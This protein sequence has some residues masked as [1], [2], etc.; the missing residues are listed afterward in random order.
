MKITLETDQHNK[1]VAALK[2]AGA[3]E[4]G[5]QLYGEQLAPSDFL[6]TDVTIQRR[7]GSVTQ[8]LVDLVQAARDA[9]RFFDR[10]R[11]R[12]SRFNYI[13]E[14]H[15]HPRFAVRPSGTDIETMRALV[16][17]P[18]FQ[19]SFAVLMIPDTPSGHF[20]E[21]VAF[22]MRYAASGCPGGRI[23]W[24]CKLPPQDAG[25]VAGTS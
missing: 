12:Y 6:V 2:H 16:R 13:G 21:S 20:P 7:R 4:I 5:G 3:R 15:S 23:V 17:D 1:L 14:W 10:S 11:H 8:F 9:V 18:E 25:S 22:S 24:P 19:G